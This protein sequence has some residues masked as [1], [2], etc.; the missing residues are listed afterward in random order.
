M[1]V[2][3]SCGQTFEGDTCPRCQPAAA[4]QSGAPVISDNIA[5]ALCYLLLLITGVL[6]LKLQ[7]YNR[8]PKVR[9][10]AFQSIF[11]NLAIII[12]WGAISFVDKRLAL[13]I[14]PVYLLACLVLWLL[15]IS[16]A[17]QNQ[18][19]V[20]PLIGPIAERRA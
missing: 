1:T 18:R 2:C 11:V 9:F 6:F 5:S 8:N 4:S 12:F 16:A 15:L 7:P 17:W 20:L 14:S 3:P 13:L 19:V 10:H